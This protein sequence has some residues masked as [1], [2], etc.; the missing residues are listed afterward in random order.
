MEMAMKITTLTYIPTALYQNIGFQKKKNT[1]LPI[2]SSE[3]IIKLKL[4]LNLSKL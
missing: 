2:S 3:H 1:G 4:I